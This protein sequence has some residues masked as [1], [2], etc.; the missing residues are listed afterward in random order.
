MC[1]SWPDVCWLA[2]LHTVLLTV[3]QS[4]RDGSHLLRSCSDPVCDALACCKPLLVG[5]APEVPLL[6][7]P[8]RH[9]LHTQV[10]KVLKSDYGIDKFKVK[11][12]LKA[13]PQAMAQGMGAK[14]AKKLRRASFMML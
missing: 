14:L 9:C 6:T 2:A 13:G 10:S 3:R 11:S 5:W 12:S 7:G 8:G 4:C 1:C